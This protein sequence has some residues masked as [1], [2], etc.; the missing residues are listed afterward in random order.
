M[1]YKLEYI[2]YLQKEKRQE[3][4]AAKLAA[5]QRNISIIINIALIIS[6]LIL[7]GQIEKLAGF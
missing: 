7:G 5:A 6:I 3:R 4:E 1:Q 2:E